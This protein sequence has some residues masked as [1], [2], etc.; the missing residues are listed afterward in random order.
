MENI[1]KKIPESSKKH[2]ELATWHSIFT[3]DFVVID[4]VSNLQMI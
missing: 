1:Q 3:E 4:I 2:N